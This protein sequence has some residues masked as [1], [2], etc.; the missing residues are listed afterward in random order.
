M[1][2]E[3]LQQQAPAHMTVFH[4]HVKDNDPRILESM[5]VQYN[6]SVVVPLT[7]ER[8]DPQMGEFCK[9]LRKVFGSEAEVLDPHV[10]DDSDS[11]LRALV[12]HARPKSSWTSGI[13]SDI[14]EQQVDPDSEPASK[15]PDPQGSSGEG[16]CFPMILCVLRLFSE[17][18]IYFKLL[19]L[20]RHPWVLPC[21]KLI[22]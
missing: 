2:A 10:L 7:P 8:D 9:T 13:Q 14:Q 16:T 3:R 1:K 20:H 22:I 21:L 5:R 11:V 4:C 17:I 19:N 18:T 15:P 12:E 6:V